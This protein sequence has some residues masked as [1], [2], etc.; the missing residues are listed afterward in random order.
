MPHVADSTGRVEGRAAVGGGSDHEGPA[1][2]S[3]GPVVAWLIAALVVALLLAGLVVAMPLPQVASAV[4]SG[5]CIAQAR[6]CS[7]RKPRWVLSIVLGA[8]LTVLA[9]AAVLG[10]NLALTT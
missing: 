8:V 3:R 9:L 2:H 4:L 6:R 1:V 10:A 7:G 5:A